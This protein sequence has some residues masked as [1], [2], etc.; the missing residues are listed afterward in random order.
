MRVA[1]LHMTGFVFTVQSA[2]QSV[3]ICPFRLDLRSAFGD[4]VIL[5][6]HDFPVCL[7]IQPFEAVKIH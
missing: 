6:M 1:D 3:E 5:C 7:F 4:F 2:V